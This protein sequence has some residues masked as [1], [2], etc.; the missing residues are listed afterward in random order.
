MSNKRKGYLAFKPWIT[1]MLAQPF[2]PKSPAYIFNL[3]EWLAGWQKA[4]KEWDNRDEDFGYDVC[5]HC[6]M[7]EANG[8]YCPA[9]GEKL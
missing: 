1:P 2:D 8:N 7:G 3:E 4:Q 6:G 9:C 5:P